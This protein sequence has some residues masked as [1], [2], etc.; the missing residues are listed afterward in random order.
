MTGAIRW[1]SIKLA[2][3]TLFTVAVTVWL[4]SII[5]NIH[6][7]STPYQVEAEFSDAS[8]LLS[9]DV[10]KAAGVTVGRVEEIRVVDG[11]ALV[12][13]DIE[14]GIELPD[15]VGAQIRFRN[16]VG[17]RMVT[18]VERKGAASGGV[19][20]DGARIPL[21]R[22][23]PAFDLTALF[24]GL[25]PLIRSTDPGD[26]N[27]VTRALVGALKGRSDEVE[28]ILS[29][30]SDVADTLSSRD[31]QLSSLLDGL[32]VVT[33]DIAGR[34][35]Q[36]QRTLANL[37][38]FLGDVDATKD[39]LSAALVTLDR[40]ARR[41]DRVVRKNSK[42]ITVD[43]DDL[44]IVLDAVNDKRADLR[45]AIRALP[46]MLVAVE[47]VNSYGQWSTAH[48]IHLCK[49]DLGTCGTRELP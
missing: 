16:L 49:D 45:A 25:R 15:S 17:Q 47:R 1:T 24:N 3:F 48:V 9:G 18:F 44:S 38:D 19:L 14:D 22:T 41:L 28:N 21:A 11:L 8:G 33:T 12:T 35:A 26:I 29:N 27:V 7:F 39:E 4:A 32:N 43:L 23:A 30:V 6:L 37:N 5:G 2:I 13:M 31:Q 34:D 46:K 10:V 20:D 42:N 40:A 36:L